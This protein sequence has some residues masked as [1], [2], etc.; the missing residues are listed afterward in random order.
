VGLCVLIILFECL[1]FSLD[2]GLDGVIFML[3]QRASP[4]LSL[5]V[6]FKNNCEKKVTVLPLN[7]RRAFFYDVF[8][9]IRPRH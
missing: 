9:S 1:K 7:Y 8:R 6:V 3:S 4:N 2:R 5:T